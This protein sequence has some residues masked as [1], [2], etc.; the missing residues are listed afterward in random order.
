MPTTVNFSSL[1]NDLSAY[2]ERGGSAASD[3]TVFAQLPRLI[4]A[5]ERKLAEALKIQGQIE[6]LVDTAGLQVGNPV[7]TKPDRWRETVSL[8]YGAGSTNNSRTFL[9]ARSYEFCRTYWPDSTQTGAPEFYAD[10]NYSSW[11]VVPT[12]DQNYPLEVLAYFQPP[13]LDAD[14]QNNFWSTYAP[15]ALLYGALIESTVFLKSDDRL[16]TWTAMWQQ[17]LQLLSGQDLQKVLDR[18]TERRNA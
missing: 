10:Y 4:N 1:L 7:V 17:E 16:P 12:P 9:F 5:A 13:L 11:L 15:Q 3:P 6:V 2:L 8:N 14:N 18:A